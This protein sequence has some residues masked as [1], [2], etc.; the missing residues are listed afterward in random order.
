MKLKGLTQEEIF[1]LTRNIGNQDTGIK[2]THKP[3]AISELL[4]KAIDSGNSEEEIAKVLNLESTTMFYR[5]KYIFTNLIANLHEKVI[6]GS[7]ELKKERVKEGYITFQVANEL[8]RVKA[9]FQLRVYEFISKNNIH[10]WNDTKSI[11]ELL[12]INQYKNLENVFEELI[13]RKGLDKRFRIGDKVDLSILN[14]KLI[15]LKQ[16]ERDK[17]FLKICTNIFHDEIYSVSLGYVF[18]EIVFK[19]EKI[20]LGQKQI[21]ENKKQLLE[22]IKNLK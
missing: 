12:E 1:I 22:H 13:K 11:R 10:G 7:S 3:F 17:K 6:Y 2:S 5:H 14:E 9:D 15:Q 19:N 20:K 16:I 21:N 18:Y 8:S 4:N